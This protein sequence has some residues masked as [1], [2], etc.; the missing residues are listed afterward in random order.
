MFARAGRH[1]WWREC[2]KIDKAMTVAGAIDGHGRAKECCGIIGLNIGL[3]PQCTSARRVRILCNQDDQ[4]ATG[5]T[6]MGDAGT[7]DGGING[8]PQ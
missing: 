1:P 5:R 7:L 3:N 6:Y 2:G 4:G 8:H